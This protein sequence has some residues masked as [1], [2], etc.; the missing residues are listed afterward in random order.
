MYSSFCH[1][2]RCLSLQTCRLLQFLA[3]LTLVFLFLEN[4]ML[5]LVLYSVDTDKLLV[6][7]LKPD[8]IFK[9]LIKQLT[10]Y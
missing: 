4:M 8:F 6:T 5:G 9:F 1:S 2:L 3:K 10:Q 7:I